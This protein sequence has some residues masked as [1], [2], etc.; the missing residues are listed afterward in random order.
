MPR[1]LKGEKLLPDVI[2]DAICRC[3]NFPDKSA[4]GLAGGLAVVVFWKA[5]ERLIG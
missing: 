2:G 4:S 1:S 3:R 5:L